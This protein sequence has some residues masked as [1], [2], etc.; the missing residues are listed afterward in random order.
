[1]AWGEI[2]AAFR[3]RHRHEHGVARGIRGFLIISLQTHALDDIVFSGS[4]PEQ[5]A[6]GFPRL[7]KHVRRDDL[8]VVSQDVWLLQAYA[9]DHVKI[10]IVRYAD[11]FA[12]RN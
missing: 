11:G 9:F 7:G 1:M 12:Q 6:R 4:L 5:K 10:A 8:E 3:L 2:V